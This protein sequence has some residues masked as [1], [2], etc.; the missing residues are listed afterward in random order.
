VEGAETKRQSAF[1]S[2]LIP[3]PLLCRFYSKLL[4]TMELFPAAPA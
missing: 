1:L 2:S 4:A 3:F